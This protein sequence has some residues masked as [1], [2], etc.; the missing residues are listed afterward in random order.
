MTAG[1]LERVGSAVEEQPLVVE[2][3]AGPDPQVAGP[4]GT[5]IGEEDGG[6]QR[7]RGRRIRP[8]PVPVDVGPTR[9]VAIGRHG[10]G[11]LDV[12]EGVIERVRG[13]ELLGD[14]KG[15]GVAQDAVA[16]RQPSSGR[17]PEVRS[18][19][20]GA[21]GRRPVVEQAVDLRVGRPRAT[22][23]ARRRGRPGSHRGRS[24]GDPPRRASPRLQR[25]APPSVAGESVC[26]PDTRPQKGRRDGDLSVVCLGCRLVVATA[27]S[28]PGST[29]RRCARRHREHARPCSSRTSSSPAWPRSG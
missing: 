3:R 19:S 8:G 17:E 18:G 23:P 16:A 28:S 13:D 4:G 24:G 25:G 11:D 1:R 20:A 9:Y 12:V 6:E 21:L 27:S 14:P 15:R 10:R 7:E 29:P 26:S 2:V 5:L 22:A